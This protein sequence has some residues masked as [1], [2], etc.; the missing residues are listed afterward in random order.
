MHLDQSP[1][2]DINSPEAFFYSIKHQVSVLRQAKEKET[3]RLLYIIMGLNHLREWGTADGRDFFENESFRIINALCNYTKHLRPL[4]QNIET[5]YELE[6][7][8]LEWQDVLAVQNVFLGPPTAYF[9][10]GRN[11]M[12]IIDE[13]LLV[14]EK[15]WFSTQ[16]YS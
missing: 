9:V 6:G 15:K 4:R 12:E 3:F 1:F 7:N 14:Y 13:V 10:D 11:I 5:A 2:F 8:M 16:N